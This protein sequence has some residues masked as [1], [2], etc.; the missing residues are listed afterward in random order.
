MTDKNFIDFDENVVVVS[1]ATSGIGRPIS[2]MLADYNARL[3]LLGRNENALNELMASLPGS[4]HQVVCADLSDVASMVGILKPVFAGIGS[5]YGM[6]HCAGVIHLRSLHM[7]KVEA[8]QDQWFVNVSAGIELARLVTGRGLTPT[9]GGSLLFI[10]S[11][12]AHVG[13]PGQIG[14]CSS[15][16]AIS[17]AVRAMAVELAPKKIRVNSISPG[18]VR[19]EMTVKK[20]ML[21]ETQM[22]EIIDK[23]P[24]GD[25]QP[26][27]VARAATFLLAPQTNW[28]TGTD[29][30]VDGGFTAQ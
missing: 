5:I 17:A 25:G 8:M 26:N 3:L 1:G 15:K 24:L 11:V 2:R 13:A 14:Y 28:I 29:L 27:D 7:T 12:A 21:N 20:S 10:S 23:H 9:E 19:T 22:Q 16:G 4:G 6:C 18:F 30:V